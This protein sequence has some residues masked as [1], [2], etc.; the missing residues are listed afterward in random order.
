[1]TAAEEGSDVASLVKHLITATAAANATRFQD[2]RSTEG[3]RGGA[4][5]R[6]AGIDH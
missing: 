4:G 5:E 2:A 3:A 6:E 1:V